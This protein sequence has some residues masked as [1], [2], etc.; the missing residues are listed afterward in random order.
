LSDYNNESLKSVR[1]YS[2][3]EQAIT[4][5]FGNEINV[6]ISDRIQLFDKKLR[7][8]PFP[9][10]LTSVVAYSTLTV[11]Y[12]IEQV[13]HSRLPGLRC[14]DKV[15]GY[16]QTL[17]NINSSM[18]S[19]IKDPIRVPVSYGLE[20]GPDLADL[21]REKELNEQ[22]FID[23]HSSSTYT[24]Y[25]IG[26]VPGF[27]YLGGMNPLLSASRK[28]KPRSAVPAGSV[29]IAGLQTGIYPLITPGGWQLIGQTPLRLFD[30]IRSQPSL[31]QAGDLIQ[32]YPITVEEYKHLSNS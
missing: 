3:G 16:L 10:F 13:V 12:S 8:S 6:Q 1:F 29:G 26:F 24:V 27:A 9:G 17:E 32:F 15:C 31:F 21:C 20:R 28:Q 18:E 7:L 30:P 11:H 4:V 5:V 25:M 14:F 23:I 22:A 19:Q 2:L